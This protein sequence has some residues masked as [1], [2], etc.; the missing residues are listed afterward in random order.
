MEE[1]RLVSVI[2]V[3]LCILEKSDNNSAFITVEILHSSKKC[4]LMKV[5]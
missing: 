5:G 2:Y 4:L 3:G 1:E